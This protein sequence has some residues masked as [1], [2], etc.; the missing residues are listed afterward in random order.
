M[1]KCKMTK[2]KVKT[3]PPQDSWG[4]TPSVEE[5]DPHGL[6]AKEV[7]KLAEGHWEW[8][9]GLLKSLPEEASPGSR[10]LEYLYKTAFLHGWKHSQKEKERG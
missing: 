2:H 9:K 1:E 6:D 7:M 3:I 5:K 8:V 4:K 10:T